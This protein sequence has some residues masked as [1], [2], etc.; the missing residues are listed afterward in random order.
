MS[1]TVLRE[2]VDRV[3]VL[4]LNRPEKHNA[5]NDEMIDAW[6]SAVD[7]AVGDPDARCIL[8][9]GEGRSFSSGRD[10]NELGRRAKGETDYEFVRRAQDEMLRLTDTPKPVVAALKGTVFG[11][12]FEIALRADIRIAAS[13]VTM[14]FPEIGYGI[15]PD[16]GG[17]QLLTTLAGPSRA[18]LLIMTGDRIGADDAKTWGIVDI[19]VS[20]EELDVT[21]LDLARRLAN[22]PPLALALAKQLVDQLS[23][24]AVRR[25][26]RAELIAQTALF[27][28]DDYREAREARAEKR[29][30][31]FTGR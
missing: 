18:K 16:T 20:S 23:A 31:R 6:S 29:A 27:A 14:C 4:S 12:A 21:A 13:D 24:D 11:G 3:A 25:G 28:S 8:I 2:L 5:F 7:W 1:D 19:V 10:V 22:G 26:T 15:L 17:T 30:P 9:R